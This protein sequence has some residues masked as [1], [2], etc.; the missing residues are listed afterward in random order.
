MMSLPK[1]GSQTLGI[2]IL[3]S[4]TTTQVVD[5]TDQAA[6]R[7]L[8][9]ENTNIKHIIHC[10]TLHKPHIESNTRTDFIDVN[11]KGTLA[12]LEAAA[13]LLPYLA[14][15]VFISTTEVYG[16]AAAPRPGV[17]AAWIDEKVTPRPANIYG[18]TKRAAEDLCHLVHTQTGMPIIILRAA[19][20]FPGLDDD[21]GRREIMSDP[22]LKVCELAYRRADISDVVKAVQRA[23]ARAKDIGFDTFLISAPS[24]FSTPHSAHR[25]E[26]ARRLDTDAPSVMAEAVPRYK[27]VFAERGWTFLPRL[28]RVY[29]SAKAVARL[30]WKPEWT[31]DVVLEKLSKGER[32][33]SELTDRVGV[34]G[35]HAIPTGVYTTAARDVLA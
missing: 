26:L 9:Q 31:F 24:P 2:D 20:F 4:S 35:Y 15:F 30:G 34:R 1:D 16:Y 28:D 7:A 17:A 19:R 29:D 32:W 6:I 33:C 12:L 18:I 3:P 13:E 5:I 22:N 27:E 23:Q 10:A 25:A 14:S 11:V 21:I 8:L